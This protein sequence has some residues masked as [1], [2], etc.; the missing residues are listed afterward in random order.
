MDQAENQQPTGKEIVEKVMG[1]VEVFWMSDDENSGEAIF[2]KFAEKHAA[3]FDGAYAD[4]ENNDN[5]L[6]YTTAHKEFQQLYEAK[7]E[8]LITAQGVQVVDFF[9]ALEAASKGDD[10]M[11]PFYVEMLMSVADYQ[12]FI[13]MMKDYKNHHAKWAHY[14]SNE[15]EADCVYAIFK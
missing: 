9:T 5:K 4:P 13:L 3:V 8:E 15:N 14:R 11:A 1:E 6:E 2:N 12:Q 10:S 7:I